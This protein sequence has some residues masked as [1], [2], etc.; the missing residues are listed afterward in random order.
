MGFA[1]SLYFSLYPYVL[2]LSAERVKRTKERARCTLRVRTDYDSEKLCC[3]TR[4]A[5][6]GP[7]TAFGIVFQ[8]S[9]LLP[10][11]DFVELAHARH[12]PCKH[13]SALA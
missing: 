8:S 11:F 5:Q 10:S 7:R 12:S 1:T 13:D 9:Y 4:F 2:F 3:G 6:T